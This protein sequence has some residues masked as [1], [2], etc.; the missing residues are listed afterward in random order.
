MIKIF[1]FRVNKEWFGVDEEFAIKHIRLNDA[2]PLENP[3]EN[4]SHMLKN[5]PVLD[6][7]IKFNREPTKTT[8]TSRILIVQDN[9][10]QVG[11]LVTKIQGFVLI[12]ETDIRYGIPLVMRNGFALLP[13]FCYNKQRVYI[14]NPRQILLPQD[15]AA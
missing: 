9:L 12:D 14:I 13:T 10:C 3:R 5:I 2:Q 15:L 11:Y 8:E 4:I 6:L 1:L 7:G